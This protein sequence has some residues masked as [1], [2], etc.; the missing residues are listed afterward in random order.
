[1]TFLIRP[2]AAIV[3]LKSSSRLGYSDFG[4]NRRR[5][6]RLRAVF[7]AQAKATRHSAE[8]SR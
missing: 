1:M 2:D 4:A 3:D 7:D 6:E 5:V 8:A